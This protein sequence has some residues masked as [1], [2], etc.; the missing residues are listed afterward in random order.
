[1]KI[2]ANLLKVGI[3]TLTAIALIVGPI[4]VVSAKGRNEEQ[5]G[6]KVTVCHFNGHNGDFVTFN[7]IDHPNGNP[8]CEAEGG[9]SIEITEQ[10]CTNGHKA[11]ERYHACA[12][13]HLQA[14]GGDEDDEEVP[15]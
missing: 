1:M 6:P 12:D 10:S 5:A 7:S 9:S 14:D 3:S 8:V 13:G 2:L 11:W 15:S 4:S